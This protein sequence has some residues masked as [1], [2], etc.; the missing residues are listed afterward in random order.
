MKQLP[1]ILIIDDVYGRERNERDNFC[2]RLGLKDSTSRIEVYEPV[3]EAQFCRGQIVK[4]SEVINDLEGT[5]DVIRKGW[6]I[7]PRWALIF[8]DLHFDTGK[9]E[10]RKPEEY[11]GLTILKRLYE[12]KEY[13]DIPVVILSAMERDRI[14]QLFADHGAFDFID[15]SEMGRETLKDLLFIHGL[16]E[17]ESAVGQS[18]PFLKCLREA[19]RRA[20]AGNENI[21][22]FGET[23]TGK[24]LLAQYIHH[25]SGR[26]G[27]FNPLFTQ[28]VPETLIEDRLFGH[29]KGAFDGAKTDQTGAAEL[30]NN[31]TLFIDEFGNIPSSIQERLLRLL[32]KNSREIQR[33][34]SQEWKRLDLLVVTATNK[35]N[36]LAGNDF[37]G[38]LLFRVKAANPIFLPPLRER[39]EDILLLAAFF[40]RKYEN[41]FNA[42]HRT[43]SEEAKELLTSYDWPGNIRQLENIIEKAVYNYKGLKVLSANHLDFGENIV[44]EHVETPVLKTSSTKEIP[45][46]EPVD[47]NL[48]AIIEAL[49]N[50]D[51]NLLKKEQLKGKLP[52]I[53]DAYAQ[54]IAKFLASSLRATQ[55]Y[56]SKRPTGEI[57]YHPAIKLITDDFE[58]KATP[59][60]R[61]LNSLL[62]ISPRALKKLVESDPVLKETIELYG[63]ERLKSEIGKH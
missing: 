12:I 20:A 43:I 16:I 53:E 27:A 62:K 13:R 44:Q 48:D 4:N 5:I 3:A 52:V 35:L 8:L 58:M 2:L 51:F 11:F 40:V 59:A 39:K 23:G 10:D 56:T 63:D 6:E 41:S 7:Y 15:K 26:K 49:E 22:L 18:V 47:R 45:A 19:R 29:V 46:R 38:D 57:S 17:T 9:D 36:I 32:D 21:L 61:L 55:I 14:E 34:G 1:R 30:A 60:K 31:G 50:F 24:E 28:G 33:L 54:F 37:R 25:Q 42:N